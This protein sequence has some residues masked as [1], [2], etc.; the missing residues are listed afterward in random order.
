MTPQDYINAQE[1][2]TFEALT[3]AR[4]ARLADNATD[5]LLYHQ[6]YRAKLQEA[7]QLAQEWSIALMRG[8]DSNEKT[9]HTTRPTRGPEEPL[10][11]EI[12]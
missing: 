4:N 3:Y 7:R 10:V 11:A 9:Q 12:Q 6:A 2:I 5:R 1:Q 8:G